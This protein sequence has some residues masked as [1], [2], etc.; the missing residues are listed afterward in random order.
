MQSLWQDL[1]HGARMLLKRPG[2]T[3]IVVI[4]LAVGIGANA[5]DG[6]RKSIPSSRCDVNEFQ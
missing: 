5:R 2:F 4:T 3:L 1:R 6:Q